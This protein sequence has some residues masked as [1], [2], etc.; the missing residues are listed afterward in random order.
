MDTIFY[1]FRYRTLNKTI[2]LKINWGLNECSFGVTRD[3]LI[4]FIP[5]STSSDN[6][7]NYKQQR[8]V[9]SELSTTNYSVADHIL[10]IT[11]YV[12]YLY[13]F[14]LTIS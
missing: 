11:Y 2:L 10:T 13:P 1:E 3:S 12:Y 6:Y 4:N 5:F 9:K 14:I 7:F 8:A